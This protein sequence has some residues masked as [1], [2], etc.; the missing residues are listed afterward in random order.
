MFH[1]LGF[2]FIIIIAIL[3]I[4]LS[5]I[6]TVIRNIF[7][8]ADAVLPPTPVPTK[9]EMV[10]TSREGIPTMIIDNRLRRH[11]L[12]KVKY[13]PATRNCSPKTRESMWIL[14]KSRSRD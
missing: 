4:G 13:V 7:G 14:K 2:L 10:I 8:L 3:L 12:K 9:K 5:I 11:K 1:I 6:G